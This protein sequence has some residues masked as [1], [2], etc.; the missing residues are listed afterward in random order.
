MAGGWILDFI[1]KTVLVTGA[2][3]GIGLGIARGFSAAGANLIRSPMTGVYLFLASPRAAN[4]TG[5]TIGADRG[6]VAY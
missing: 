6:E 1:G 3:R 5:Q 2:S 4:I